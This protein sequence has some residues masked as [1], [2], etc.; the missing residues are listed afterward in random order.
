MKKPIYL[1]YAAST[2]LDPRVFEKMKPFMEP[3]GLF[4]NPTSN[5]YYGIESQ[6]AIENA[7]AQVASLINAEAREIIW[8]SGATESNNL[9][10]KGAAY[11]YQNRGR[12]IVTC[13][14]E[15][16][17]VLQCCDFLQSQGFEVTYLKPKANGIIDLDQLAASLRPDTILVSIMHV[18]NELGVIQD[19][20]AIGKLTREKSI[21]FHVDAVQGVGKLAIDLK[22]LNVDLMSFTAHKLYGPKGIGALYIRHKPRARI[23]PQIHGGS[24]E[25]GLRSGT[26]ATHQIVGM[27][28]SF[29]LAAQEMAEEITQIHKLYQQF[30]NGIKSLPGI[31]LNGDSE[32]RIAHIVNVSFDYIDGEALLMSL[33]ELAVST[34][35][36]CKS[37]SITPSHVLL[38]LDIPPQLAHSAVRFSF[39]RFTTEAE[40]EQ[41]VQIVRKQVQRLL[42]ISPLWHGTISA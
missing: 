30:W 35:S 17:A 36:A 8:T 37:H 7:R 5:H 23:Q 41:A 13:Q 25:Q 9:A 20:A 40:I 14:T 38:A 34:G 32:Q 24:H 11:F 39:G 31:Q 22:Q 18:N 2:P 12:H 42:A 1:D 33:N 6:K 4:G 3:G 29:H 27:G 26:L 16:K 19:I 15:H 28:E 21:L 10:I